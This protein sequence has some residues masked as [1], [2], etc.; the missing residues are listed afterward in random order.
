MLFVQR[1]EPPSSF[2]D[3]QIA[4][5]N[6]PAETYSLLIAILIPDPVK[7]KPVRSM[8]LKHPLELAE[9]LNGLYTV[10]D[11]L[12]HL[13]RTPHRICCCR[14]RLLLWSLLR[15]LLAQTAWDLTRHLFLRRAHPSR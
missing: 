9:R 7:H 4:V 13:Q 5:K 10:R 11:V 14:R 15:H 6:I 3:P 2:Y 1:L 8:R 12:L